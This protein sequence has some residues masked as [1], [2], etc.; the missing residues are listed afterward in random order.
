M[1]TIDIAQFRS[2]LARY[3]AKPI[4]DGAYPLAAVLVP[5]YPRNGEL[6]VIFT[7]RTQ[8]VTRHKGEIS[9]PGGAFTLEDADLVTTALRETHE[10]IGVRPEDVEVIGQLDDLITV[11]DFRV[12][13]YVGVIRRSPYEFIANAFE[14][15]TIIEV[16]V[17]H[18]LDKANIVW[19]RRLRNGR[20]VEVQGYA[21]EEHVIWG[22]TAGIL[23]QLLELLE[24]AEQA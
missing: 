2:V 10:E 17:S 23:R 11:S 13:P 20:E 21:F 16:P 22:A 15:E 24:V 5:V 9:F 7:K 4:A 8:F 3:T 1:M 18:L 12:T 19:E 14:V 6:H